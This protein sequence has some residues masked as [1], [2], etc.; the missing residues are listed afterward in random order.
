VRRYYFNHGKSEFNVLW[1]VGAAKADGSK[2]LICCASEA[3][4]DRIV[5]RVFELGAYAQVTD[6]GVV[7]SAEP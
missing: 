3:S 4:V 7:V 1:A 2:T 6:A 5:Q